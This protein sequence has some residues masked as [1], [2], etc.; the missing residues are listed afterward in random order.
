MT[1]IEETLLGGNQLKK[2]SKRLIWK[3]S[4]EIK[5]QAERLSKSETVT[6]LENIVLNPMQIR[7]FILSI[8][9]NV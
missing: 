7:S 6:N 5:K 2:D 8:K 3:E 9:Q 1:S 4:N